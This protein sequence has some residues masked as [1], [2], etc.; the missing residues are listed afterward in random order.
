VTLPD[1]N[2][3]KRADRIR[4]ESA[5]RSGQRVIPWEQLAEE[6]REGWRRAAGKK[7]KR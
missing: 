2:L 6:A 1:P 5:E 7:A 4:R 3:D